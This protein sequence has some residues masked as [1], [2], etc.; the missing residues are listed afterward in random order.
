MRIT[1]QQCKVAVSEMMDKKT[2]E[3]SA[4]QLFPPMRF[5]ID[6][7]SVPWTSVIC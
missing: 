7:R 4:R 2:L 1:M 6:R 5:P 3:K